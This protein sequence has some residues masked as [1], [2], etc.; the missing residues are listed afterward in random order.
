M[1]QNRRLYLIHWNSTEAEQ[2]A[3]DLRARGWDVFAVHD[4]DWLDL[5]TLKQSP[6]H[7]VAISL[8]R[9]PLHGR[10]IADA[11]WNTKWGRQIPIAF[12]DGAEDKVAA[13]RQKFPAAIYTSWEVLP[14]LL[15]R[16]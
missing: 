7:A 1:E 16:L 8:R 12:F 2:L 14:A 4:S 13:T 11:L 5:K 6:P 15:E 10:A 9:L 3:D